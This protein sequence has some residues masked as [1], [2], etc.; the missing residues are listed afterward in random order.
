MLFGCQLCADI[1]HPVVLVGDSICRGSLEGASSCCF[2]RLLVHYIVTSM[3]CFDLKGH[4]Q[5]DTF[6]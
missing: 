3:A 2:C 1:Q 6:M 4:H 5:V